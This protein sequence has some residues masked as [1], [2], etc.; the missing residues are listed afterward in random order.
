MVSILALWN[1]LNTINIPSV[2]FWGICHGIR[3]HNHYFNILSSHFQLDLLWNRKQN[4]L[5]NIFDWPTRPQAKLVVLAIANTMDLPERIMKNR[6]SSR[7]VRVDNKQVSFAF[8]W[9]ITLCWVE[10]WV[11]LWVYYW[12]NIAFNIGSN[13][14]SNIGSNIGSHIVFNIGFNFVFN[15]GFNWVQY[16]VQNWV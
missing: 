3:T 15:I 9:E 8:D 1:F 7:L 4:V 12:V 6:V 2:P 16:S 5:Y 10:Y 11:W 13:I 14:R